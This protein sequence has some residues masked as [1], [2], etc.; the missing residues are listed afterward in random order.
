MFKHAYKE[1]YNNTILVSSKIVI[2]IISKPKMNNII[3][4]TMSCV[5]VSPITRAEPL[6][7]I[8]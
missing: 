3:P 1:F 5:M 6:L 4:I 2:I 7:R 8:I